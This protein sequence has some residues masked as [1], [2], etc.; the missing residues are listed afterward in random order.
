MAGCC[1]AVAVAFVDGVVGRGS[2]FC[3][4]RVRVRVLVQVHSHMAS[5]AEQAVA[6]MVAKTGARGS[7][8]ARPPQVHPH[9]ER[10]FFVFLAWQTS[11][12]GRMHQ[13]SLTN[14]SRALARWAGGETPNQG[15]PTASVFASLS[16]KLKRPGLWL[17]RSL[18]KGDCLKAAPGLVTDPSLS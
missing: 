5:D 3:A 15:K 12:P 4:Q 8:N 7:G 13:A 18:L 2:V 9:V 1:S 6:R 16:N 10:D 11:M 17:L 14:A